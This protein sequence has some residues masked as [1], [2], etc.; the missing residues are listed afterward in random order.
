MSAVTME[1]AMDSSELQQE[2]KQRK[3][4]G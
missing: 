3:T 1:H 4:W 2:I